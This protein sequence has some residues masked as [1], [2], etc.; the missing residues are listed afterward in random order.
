MTSVG[1]ILVFLNLLMSLAV[2]AMIVLIFTSRTRWAA[3]YEKA[4]NSALVA[5]AAYKT[6]KLA[7]ESDVKSRDNQIDSLGK[8]NLTLATE[9]DDLKKANRDLSDV[10]DKKSEEISKEQGINTTLR[11]EVDTLKAERGTLTADAQAQRAKV[12]ETQQLLNTARLDAQNKEIEANAQTQKARR[13][14]ER[15]EEVEKNNTQLVNKINSLGGAGASSADSILKPAPTPAPR[16]VYGTVKAVAT[17][18]LT[19]INIGSDSGISAGNKL[20][21]YRPDNQN[22]KNSLYLGELVVSRTE[23]KQA[24]G[25][26]YPKPF[27]KPDERLPKENDV[28]ST[29][30]GSR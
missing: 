25:Q 20:L 22:P 28:V 16:D 10:N 21:I 6:E 5:E 24:V 9:R 15:L 1:K 12:I 19:V 11:G 14:L 23:P 30:L 29:S 3:E 13:L 7:H 17:S 2:A 27:A 8:V 26:F 4:R 18:G